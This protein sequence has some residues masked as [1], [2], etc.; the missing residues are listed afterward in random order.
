MRYEYR[1]GGR[2]LGVSQR[3]AGYQAIDASWGRPDA[4]RP[5]LEFTGTFRDTLPLELRK[6]VL[7]VDLVVETRVGDLSFR[8]FTGGIRRITP[9]LA[10]TQIQAAS[11]GY[12]L[13]KVRFDE[14]ATYTDA[15]P[16]EVVWDVVTRANE[17]GV[18]DLRG[19]DIERVDGPKVRREE[20]LLNLPIDKLSRALA[21]AVEEGALFFRDSPTNAPLC[22]PD[23]G[24]AEAQD[25]EWE[26]AVGV[27]VDPSSWL[28]ET[29]G[30]EFDAVLPYR[31][32]DGGSIEFILETN[33]DPATRYISIPG[34]VAPRGASYEINISDESVT[35][36][37]DAFHL[38]AEA[39]LRLQDGESTTSVDLK[40][41]HPLL[42]DGDFTA[43]SEPGATLEGGT[44]TR[45]WIAKIET[46]NEKGDFT[47]TQ[48]LLMVVASEETEASL[49]KVAAY[50]PVR[51]RGA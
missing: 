34:S 45:R 16:S 42:V 28:P 48:E 1:A 8:R 40:W 2:D 7:S 27:D 10:G 22:H 46:L 13:D 17:R 29:T 30:D 3:G 12:W 44:G 37:A 33:S 18:Y 14:V 20:F 32:K 51:Q 9:T 5:A 36:S 25:V 41:P 47:Q 50:G 15:S 49:G 38:C 26:Y 43:W 11:G 19:V 23:R 6:E 4:E 24:P 35:A 39:A 21:A 31:A